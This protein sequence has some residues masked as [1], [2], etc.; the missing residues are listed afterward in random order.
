MRYQIPCTNTNRP[1]MLFLQQ[2][3]GYV[4]FGRQTGHLRYQQHLL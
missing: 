2:G 4:R 3:K 1:L